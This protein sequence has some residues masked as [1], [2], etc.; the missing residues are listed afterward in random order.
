MT[1][2]ASR[3]TR[4]AWLGLG[5][6]CVGLASA[7]AVLP[8]LP[9]VPLLL[10]AAWAYAH[11][12]PELRDRLY[13]HPRY[14]PTL[15]AWRDH[16]V[17]PRRAKIAAVGAFALSVAVAAWTTGSWHVPVL[18]AAIVTTVGAYVLTRPERPPSG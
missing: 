9:T 15:R 12:A 13:A 14:G 16:R 4:W 10:V 1:R 17:V 2:P 18:V 7:G 8:L 5:H 3:R 6:A 11:G